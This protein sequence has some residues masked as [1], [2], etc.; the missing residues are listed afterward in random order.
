MVLSVRL[1]LAGLTCKCNSVMSTD[2]WILMINNEAVFLFAISVVQ[3]VKCVT[4]LFLEDWENRVTN[5]EIVY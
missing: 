4:E 5:V 2:Y 3:L 1:A